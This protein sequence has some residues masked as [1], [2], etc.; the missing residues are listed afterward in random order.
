MRKFGLFN[1]ASTLDPGIGVGRTDEEMCLIQVSLY[2]FA[3]AA[4]LGEK[5]K[6]LNNRDEVN[7]PADNVSATRF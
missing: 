2:H 7:G 1:S 5:G 3:I 6:T 4:T